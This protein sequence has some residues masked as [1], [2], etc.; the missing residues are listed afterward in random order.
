MCTNLHVDS[1]NHQQAVPVGCLWPMV[2]RSLEQAI[3]T[4]LSY[5]H[6]NLPEI[7]ITAVNALLVQCIG[8]FLKLVQL[9]EF[10]FPY[11]QP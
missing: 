6:Q 4:T 2:A 7:Y 9:L 5:I 1:E 10:N 11:H 3:P 8:L